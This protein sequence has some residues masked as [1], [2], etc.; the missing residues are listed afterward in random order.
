MSTAAA[1]SRNVGKIIPMIPFIIKA[2]E[3]LLEQVFKK[4]TGASPEEGDAI[5]NA[6]IQANYDPDKINFIMQIINPGMTPDEIAQNLIASMKDIPTTIDQIVSDRQMA[7]EMQ[8][9]LGESN[10]GGAAA[11][12]PTSYA[13]AA[14]AAAPAAVSYTHLPLPTKRIV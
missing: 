10:G 9:L 2:A 6:L 11:A 12:A 8:K 1:I 14:A 5:K 7:E 4:A 13:A 3:E